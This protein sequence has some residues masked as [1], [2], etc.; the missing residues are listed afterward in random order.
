[1]TNVSH[2]LTTA[3]KNLLEGL[4]RVP[5]PIAVISAVL[6]VFFAAPVAWCSARLL[7]RASGRVNRT[8]PIII[9]G[10]K[11]NT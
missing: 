2:F 7:S 9:P 3:L 4:Y 6:V 10:Q 1:M 11:E 8:R 5:D